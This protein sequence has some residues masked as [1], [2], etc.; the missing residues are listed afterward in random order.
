MFPFVAFEMTH[1]RRF[2]YITSNWA[3]S[4]HV[5]VKQPQIPRFMYF[6]ICKVEHNVKA[7]VLIRHNKF[8][9]A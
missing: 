3:V 8:T 9:N 2:E 4:M 5:V 7:T 1:F 6:E